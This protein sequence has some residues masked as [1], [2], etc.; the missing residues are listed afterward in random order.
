MHQFFVVEVEFG[1]RACF[2]RLHKAALAGNIGC[3]DR[4]EATFH[5]TLLG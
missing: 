3:Q 1:R 4:G 2:V 5:E